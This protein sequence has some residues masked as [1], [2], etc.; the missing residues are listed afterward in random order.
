MEFQCPLMAGEKELPFFF[1]NSSPAKLSPTGHCDTKSSSQKETSHNYP[2]MPRSVE[3]NYTASWACW[4][5]KT[6]MLLSGKKVIQSRAVT[7]SLVLASQTAPK[8]L[9]TEIST[10]E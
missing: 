6:G 4:R 5:N 2:P 1:C 7:L 8:T 10:L 3:S 9:V